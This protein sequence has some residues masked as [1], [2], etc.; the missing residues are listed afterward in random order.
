ME[1][2]Q[3]KTNINCGEC[4]AQ[5]TPHLNSVKGIEKWEVNTENLDRILTVI[6]DGLKSN[7]IQEA[8]TRILSYKNLKRSLVNN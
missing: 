4:V 2:Y 6:T 8:V 5:V 7:Q 3:F 1:K